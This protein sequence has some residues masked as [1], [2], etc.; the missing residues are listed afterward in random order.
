[1][2]QAPNARPQEQR[3]CPPGLGG[4]LPGTPGAQMSLLTKLPTWCRVPGRSTPPPSCRGGLRPS[5]APVL[6]PV[7]PGPPSRPAWP[8]APAAGLLPGPDCF[9]SVSPVLP[10]PPR[11]VSESE[12]EVLARRRC[13]EKRGSWAR[14]S[15]GLYF[16][17]LTMP[18]STTYFIPAMVM[19]VSAMLVE[20][21]T[22]RQP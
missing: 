8:L 7:E 17:A 1:M 18:V 11:S 21:I 14:F 5:P 9:Q 2:R 16:F 12:Q 15:P 20:M 19:E 3:A 10:A 6:K 4:F 13:G 22:L